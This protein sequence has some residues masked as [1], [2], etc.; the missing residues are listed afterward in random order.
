MTGATGQTG[1]TGARTFLSPLQA[2]CGLIL[3]GVQVVVVTGLKG[4]NAPPCAGASGFTGVTGA[5]GQTGV[6]GARTFL[7]PL[8]ACC[9][10]IAPPHRASG[11][12]VSK[13]LRSWA[14]GS[15]CATMH[16]GASGFTGV[17]GATGQT[18]VTGA[19]TFLSPLQA[20]CGLILEGVQVVVVMGLRVSMRRHV[21]ALVAS[22]A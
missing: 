5:T 22:P 21:Q 16:A 17:T 20:C 1:V 9:G 12:R 19:R 7:S 18:G 3:E 8:Q 2:C 11:L 15:H 4:L 6:T 10:L 13:S 14:L